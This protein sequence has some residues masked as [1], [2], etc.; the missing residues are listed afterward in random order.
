MPWAIYTTA[1]LLCGRQ[2]HCSFAFII[3]EHF[4][5][6]HARPCI[7][8]LQLFW[9]APSELHGPGWAEEEPRAGRLWGTSRK[10]EGLVGKFHF[11][12][13][14][15]ACPDCVTVCLSNSN[16]STLVVLLR[17]DVAVCYP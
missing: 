7:A 13:H 8:Y 11:P 9:R 3:R 2:Y 15:Y 17:K 12:L 10:M 6:W 4:A 16:T 14:Y 5:K 1:Y